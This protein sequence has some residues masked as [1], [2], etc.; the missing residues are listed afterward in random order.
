MFQPVEGWSE[1][2]F[3]LQS[4]HVHDAEMFWSG[5]EIRYWPARLKLKRPAATV[6]K[7]APGF[8]KWLDDLTEDHR[9][10]FPE[11]IKPPCGSPY[12]DGSSPF[13]SMPGG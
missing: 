5:K 6:K 1:I 9:V 12:L 11:V 10:E 3:E 2:F 13:A 4:A 8:S 7:A